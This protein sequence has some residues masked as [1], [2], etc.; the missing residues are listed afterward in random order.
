MLSENLFIKYINLFKN[1]CEWRT[2]SLR[3]K[4]V[5]SPL[6]SFLF[7]ILFVS[8]G[9]AAWWLSQVPH[10]SRVEGFD[11]GLRSAFGWLI[12]M[13]AFPPGTLVSSSSLKPCGV[14]RL[15][16]PKFLQCVSVSVLVPCGELVHQKNT[17]AF[18]SIPVFQG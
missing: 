1:P 9:T 14:G 10:T 17:L 18:A 2:L 3:H 16:F 4:C 7:F 12:H 15:A 11:F 13:H 5:I 8:Y 6:N